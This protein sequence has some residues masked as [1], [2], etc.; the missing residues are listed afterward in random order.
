MKK[1]FLLLLLALPLCAQNLH[2]RF[3]GIPFNINGTTPVNPFNGGIDVPRYQFT[4]I[5]GDGDLDLFIFDRDTT[6]NFYKNTGTAS[7][8]VYVMFT[9]RYENL[10]IRNWF[11]FVDID[12]DN[13][14]DLFCGGDSQ[15]VMYYKNIGTPTNPAFS[16]QTYSVKTNLNEDMISES[17]CV[18]TFA[19]M[20]GDG[21]IDFFTGSSSGK[22]THYEN[23]GNANNFLF[24]F[25]TDFW[26]G[27]EIIGAARP[28]DKINLNQLT[29][30]GGTLRH[31]A[32]AIMFGDTDGDGDKDLY[33]GDFFGFSVYFIKN[34]GTVQN[35]A[36][37]TIDT[38]SPEPNPYYSGGF[39]MPGIYDINGDGRNDMFI[40]VLLGSKS[41][42]NFL[43]YR[44]DG[45]LNN[46][47]FTRVTNNFI[48]SADIGSYSYPTF[49][50][51][52]NDG[53]LDLFIGYDESVAFFRNT[54]S[55]TQP[56]YNLEDDSLS[57]G[58]LNNFNYSV[59]I[60]DLDG[61]GKKDL[62]LGYY[63]LAKLKFYK[64]T[65]TVQN[66]AFTLVPSQLDTM[67]LGQQSAPTLVDID[68]DGDLDLFAGSSNGRVFYYR[69]IGTAAAFNFQ[70]VTNTYA[71]INT[72]NDATPS[73]GD[74]DNDGDLD[75]LIGTRRGQIQ[76]YRNDGTAASPNFTL[77]TTTFLNINVHEHSVPCIVDINNDGDK[78]LIIGNKK[79]GLFYYE[80]QDVFGIQQTGTGIPV[81]Y[82]LEQNYPNPFNPNT[83]IRF[84]MAKDGV[85]EL[86]IYNVT[87]QEIALLFS[88][89]IK[90]GSY[91]ADWDASAFP[92]GV[93]FYRLSISEKG[94][95]LF[96]ET[97]K[98]VLVK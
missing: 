1:I 91:V 3:D 84:H 96:N 54:G 26:K 55:S 83:S 75:M 43:Y 38:T 15:H 23:I 67:T 48:V 65:G 42:D 5:D 49:A 4:D 37:T 40:G 51:I 79:G 87:G 29:D 64:N 93:Y 32:S 90:A 14:K 10:S 56:S 95:A 86:K 17:A 74:M 50:D 47:A 30:D 6:L 44:N 12:G 63:A 18:P 2:I 71:G 72:G 45:P 41:I 7:N 24:R 39:N 8:P 36:F 60:G 61:D 89:R 52:D 25:V 77:V 62:V 34:T 92:S 98:M 59:A 88:R 81:K 13:D 27:I 82:D 21:D 76:H 97:R 9:R 80:N 19:D 85:A 53:D 66:P 35:F 68:N 70:F 28:P 31:G 11:H 69:N 57:V 73:F 16:F 78:D 33:W 22:I 58:V 94:T 20:D 46:P